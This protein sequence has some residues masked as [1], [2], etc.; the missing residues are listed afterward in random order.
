[1]TGGSDLLTANVICHHHRLASS[2]FR[3]TLR[4]L[5]PGPPA[6]S[7][8]CTTLPSIIVFF[9]LPLTRRTPQ[10][11][12]HYTERKIGAALRAAGG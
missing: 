2:A 5:T 1:V 7:H 3:F 10:T 11:A 9:S 6:W 8:I 12:R 4:S